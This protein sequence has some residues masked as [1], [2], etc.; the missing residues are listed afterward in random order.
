MNIL[1]ENSQIRSLF[2]SLPL[3]SKGLKFATYNL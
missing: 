2:I 1:I 3:N